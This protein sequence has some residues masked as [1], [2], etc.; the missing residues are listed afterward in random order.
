MTL[1]NVLP[2]LQRGQLEGYAVG[3]YNANNLEQIQAI[4]AAAEAE[5]APAIIQI[6]HRALKYFGSGD[7]Q[8]GLEFVV[9]AVQVAAGHVKAPISLHLDHAPAEVVRQAI[10]AGFTSVMFDGGDLPLQENIAQTR[11]LRQL[12]HERGVCIEAEVGEVPR[13]DS[14]GQFAPAG[15]FT[16][17]EQALEFVT[18]TGIDVLAIAI[19]SVH[20]VRDKR[21]VLNL[22]RLRAI[23]QRVDIPLVLHGSSGVA[24]EHIAE[25]IRLGLS[26]VNIATQLNQAFTQALRQALANDPDLIDPRL[27]LGPARQAQT[28][29]IQE[30][31]RFLGASGKA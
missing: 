6:S 13:A 3:A 1:L 23:R 9:S 26:K 12:A 5:Q 17:P 15:E 21:V 19:G 22:D 18:A 8:L 14:Q 27:Y 25:G 2:W 30:R 31:M 10:A 29:A 28:R 11:A 24:D 16:D 20:A 7:V 4:V